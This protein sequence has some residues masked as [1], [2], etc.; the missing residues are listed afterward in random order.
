MAQVAQNQMF[1]INLF[2]SNNKMSPVFGR[3]LVFRPRPC[4]E[5]R[6]NSLFLCHYRL[7]SKSQLFRGICQSDVCYS[8]PACTLF[9]AG[10]VL[11]TLKLKSW[12]SGCQCLSWPFSAP[13]GW[14][15]PH[16]ESWCCFLYFL[17]IHKIKKITF[18]TEKSRFYF[19]LVAAPKQLF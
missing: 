10:K 15:E 7:T 5:Y 14:T 11:L 13:S 12:Y 8:D 2:C 3:N 9:V 4:P 1:K 6:T 19:L 16:H 18:N 17:K